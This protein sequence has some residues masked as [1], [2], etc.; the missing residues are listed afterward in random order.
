M[1]AEELA[2]RP[3]LC[4]QHRARAEYLAEVRLMLADLERLARRDGCT[5]AAWALTVL[6][7]LPRPAEI[8]DE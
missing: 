6:K 8:Y 2:D 1:T 4:H 3:P 5:A 7:E